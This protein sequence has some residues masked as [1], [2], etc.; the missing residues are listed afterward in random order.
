ME[1]EGSFACVIVLKMEDVWS[2]LN[3]DKYVPIERNVGD[4]EGKTIM[5]YNTLYKMTQQYITD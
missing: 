4:V 3:A 1:S 2:C 5:C